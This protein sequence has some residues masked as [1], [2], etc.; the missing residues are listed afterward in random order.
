MIMMIMMTNNDDDD[1]RGGVLMGTFADMVFSER[2]PFLVR[3]SVK[4]WLNAGEYRGI[5][6]TVL[7]EMVWLRLWCGYLLQTPYFNSRAVAFG[8]LEP[9]SLSSS[10]STFSHVRVR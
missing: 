3:H 1:V 6:S 7:Q 2:Q 4:F 8:A 9:L 5:S 10:N